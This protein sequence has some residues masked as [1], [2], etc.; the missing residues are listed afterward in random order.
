MEIDGTN[1]VGAFGQ[2][3]V[4]SV[5]CLWVGVPVLAP[6]TKGP[7]CLWT[8]RSREPFRLQQEMGLVSSCWSCLPFLSA[9]VLFPFAALVYL[10]LNTFCVAAS[11][12]WLESQRWCGFCLI[13]ACKAWAPGIKCICGCRTIWLMQFGHV[14]AFSPRLLTSLRS[15][16]VPPGHFRSGI[17]A[18]DNVFLFFFFCFLIALKPR[19]VTL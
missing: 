12:E 1:G 17:R 2:F 16:A 10:C 7:E 3:G 8:D 18:T 13:F 11:A 15:P 14:S 5:W 9:F 19:G 6:H 4:A